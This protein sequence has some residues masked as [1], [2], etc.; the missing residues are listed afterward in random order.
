MTSSEG[1]WE[2]ED[3]IRRLCFSLDTAKDTIASLGEKGFNHPE[4]SNYRVD[5]EKIIAET[6][7]VLLEAFELIKYAEVKEK[8]YKLAIMLCPYARNDRTLFNIALYPALALDYA[9]P[10]ICLTKMGYPDDDF[11]SRVTKAI[12]LNSKTGCE[13]LPYRIIEQESIKEMWNK[14]G[15]PIDEIVL[16]TFLGHSVDLFHGTREDMYAFTH[17]MIYTS[18]FKVFHDKL[19]RNQKDILSEVDGMLA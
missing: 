6:A 8:V 10:H 19:P 3:L 13:R 17:A 9:Y 18:S 11:E 12:N 16:H 4:Q 15:N 7:F 5:P 14:R 1:R 2:C